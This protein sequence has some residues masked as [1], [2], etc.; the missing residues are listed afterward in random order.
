M[1][2]RIWMMGKRRGFPKLRPVVT[3]QSSRALTLT[4]RSD[5][6]CKWDRIKDTDVNA[7]LMSSTVRDDSREEGLF[8]TEMSCAEAF[9]GRAG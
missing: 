2:G 7:K 9:S 3:C 8:D 4:R 6:M 1:N 5:P